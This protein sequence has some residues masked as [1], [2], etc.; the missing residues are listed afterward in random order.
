[1]L[2]LRGGLEA[3]I[4]HYLTALD[5]SPNDEQTLSLVEHCPRFNTFEAVLSHSQNPILIRKGSQ[6]IVGTPKSDCRGGAIG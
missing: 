4:C 1:M 3:K 2:S 5:L 6:G